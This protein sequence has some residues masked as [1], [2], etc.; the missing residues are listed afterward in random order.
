MSS[1]RIRGVLIGLGA[2]FPRASWLVRKLGPASLKR[3]LRLAGKDRE[4]VFTSIYEDR[5]WESSE[6]VSGSGSTL[7]ATASIR[8]E[9][10]G[11]LASLGVRSLLDA[12]CGDF[13]WMSQTELDLDLYVGGEIV[14]PLVEQLREKYGGEQRR[15]E[16]IDITRDP[17]PETDAFL[18]R[19]CLLHLSHK[20]VEAVLNN[21]RGSS[22]AYLLASNYPD[23]G[24]NADIRTG[25]SRQLNLSLPPFG[26]PE[27]IRTIA[28]PGPH[29][30][31]KQLGVWDLK[32]LRG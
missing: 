24:F 8:D 2:R 11:L 25:M 14:L 9:L 27:P 30:A 23:C 21:A 3:R 32:A 10:P 16:H 29:G 15:F 28:D 31:E 7:A 22:I 19:D 13:Y 12:P 4:A 18:C 6:S 1:S 26:L 5:Y 17:L 20:E